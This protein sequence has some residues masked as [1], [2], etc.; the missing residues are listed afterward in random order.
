M[1]PSPAIA[2]LRGDDNL[3]W[4]LR[5][6]ENQ[7]HA[8]NFVQAFSRTLCVYSGATGN[9]Y[10]RYRVQ[11]PDEDGAALLVLPDAGAPAWRGIPE[12][13][14]RNTPCTILHGAI[15]GASGI[16]MHIPFSHGGG[17]PLPLA[18]GLRLLADQY[19]ERG[20]DFLP[21]LTR[22]GLKSYRRRAP[23]LQ[24]HRLDLSRL[25]GR[26]AAELAGMRRGILDKLRGVDAIAEQLLSD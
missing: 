16:F 1:H 24:L 26:S 3:V 19:T 4:N 13:A 25:R 21:V 8:V 15:L 11:L 14:V 17:R 18:S 5:E 6:F 7:R 12:R 20:E 22:G 2:A 9:L 10:A 23:M